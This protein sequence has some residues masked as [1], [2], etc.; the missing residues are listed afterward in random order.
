VKVGSKYV[1]YYIDSANET[2]YATADSITGPW[3]R[4]NKPII[5]ASNPALL[6]E[7]DGKIYLFGRKVVGSI[8]RGLAFRASSYNSAY[9]PV[10]GGDNLL[11]NDYELEDPTIWRANGQYN[12]VLSD[13]EG[14]ATGVYRQGAQYYSKDGEHYTLLSTSAVYSKTVEYSDGSSQKFARRERPFVFAE[15]SGVVTGFFTACFDGKETSIVA[16]AVS[17][18]VPDNR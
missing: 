4:L 6:V 14:K 11:P 9:V 5:S 10:S 17:N 12:V 8:N 16:Q 3:A 7:P 1:L 13:W 18:Y 15:S 2:G